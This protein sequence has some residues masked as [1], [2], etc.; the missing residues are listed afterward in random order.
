[1]TPVFKRFSPLLLLLPLALP[2]IWH[3]P[4]YLH[5]VLCRVL[6]YAI[7]V[8]SLDLVVGYIGDV[9]IG[10]AGF[11]AIGA[12]TV[13]VLTARPEFNGESTL[14]FFPQLPFLVALIPAVILAAF[15]GFLLGFPALRSS[16]PYLAVITIAY[17]LIIYTVINE[18]ER[19]TNGTKGITLQALSVGQVRL[20]G[21]YF[22]FLVYPALV[23]VLYLQRN[24]ARSFWGRAFE[25][26]KY[27]A[28]AAECCGIS[29]AYYK[30]WAFVL[31]AGIAGFAGGLFAQLD[32]YVGP[33]T[34]SYN[35]SV[36]LLIALIFGGVRSLTGNV[37]GAAVVVVL[38][39]VFS[40]FADYRLMVYGTLLLVVLFFM[41]T[42]I[43][44]A[45]RGLFG[46]RFGEHRQ[47][48]RAGLVAA[49]AGL[50]PIT[51][52]ATEGSAPALQLEGVT[53]RFGGLTA[54]NQLSVKLQPGRVLGLIGPN[55]S[56]KST[57]VN[58]L[59][60]VYFPSEGKIWSFGQE[61]TRKKAH[62]RAEKGI[63]RTF[64]N[65]QL[66][67]QLT[68][69]ENV[70]VGLHLSFKATLLE[71][72]LGL[73]KVKRE[74]QAARARAFALLRFVGLEAAAFTAA[75][76]LSYG[77][78]RHLEIARALAL[79]PRLL[80]LDEPAA[81]L[82][83]GEIEEINRLIGKIKAKGISVLLIEHHMDMVMAISDEVTVLDFGKQIAAGT[84]REV[85]ENP[86][87]IEAYL[88][89]HVTSLGQAT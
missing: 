31:S 65:L 5:G 68:A 83:G 61:V 71:V 4:Y 80:L 62:E 25:A 86:M 20:N 14:A 60:G 23:L 29:R 69:L 67:G 73:P 17:G 18:S 88:G 30:I 9:S 48:E 74:E 15:A 16:G 43:L 33:T 79:S 27:S 12:Y 82:T 47:D 54:V 35:F 28:V 1:M 77:Q 11:F 10:H 2:L 87:V 40:R 42:G 38:P 13:A 72:L 34:F 64:Q 44:G 8:A 84:P 7:V 58:L 46:K 75:N 70:L 22:F 24:L 56:G 3:N 52:R 57:T 26:L 51:A 66:F 41:P 39:D 32:S 85:Q 76:S 6:V 89:K 63:S 21:E 19:L 78:A 45:V 50:D 37:L 49:A 36:E 55:G 81:G 53:M 59:T